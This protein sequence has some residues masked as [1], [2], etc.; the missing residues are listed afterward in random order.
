MT[1]KETMELGMKLGVLEFLLENTITC[2][3]GMEKEGCLKCPACKLRNSGLKSFLVEHPDF[4]F[5]Y[6]DKILTLV[7]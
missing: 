2:Y 3:E 7:I 6:R 5:S 4:Q 1:K